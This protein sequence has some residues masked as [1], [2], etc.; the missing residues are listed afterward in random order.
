MSLP[1]VAELVRDGRGATETGSKGNSLRLGVGQ[2]Q[3]DGPLLVYARSSIPGTIGT[4]CLV[5]L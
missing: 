5:L 4:L 3:A 2:K 1:S